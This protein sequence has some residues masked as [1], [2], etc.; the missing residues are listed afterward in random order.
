[1]KR[2]LTGAV[3][4]SAMAGL[5]ASAFGGTPTFADAAA[6]TDQSGA[7]FSAVLDYQYSGGNQG[8]L[9]INIDNETPGSLGGYM[10]ALVF[11]IASADQTASA[12]LQTTSLP[13]FRDA[14][15]VNASPFGTSFRGGA[16][17]GGNWNHSGSTSSGLNPGQS[18]SFTFL[19]TASDAAA[20]DDMSFTD[21]EYERNFVVRFRKMNTAN[22]DKVPAEI[23]IPAPG[24]VALM[25]LAGLGV[26]RRRR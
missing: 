8:L 1:M 18:A 26:A 23:A 19:I 5:T 17:I 12:V 3:A 11:N 15:Y 9:T 7:L 22:S 20:L 14:Q 25:G 4:L 2:T 24:A 13:Q 21:G 16:A 10:T 6:A